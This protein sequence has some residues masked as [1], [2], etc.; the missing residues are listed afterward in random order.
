MAQKHSVNWI[1]VV[2]IPVK[3]KR[4]PFALLDAAAR[5]ADLFLKENCV[6]RVL[7]CVI[8]LSIATGHPSTAQQMWPSKM[9]LCALRMGTVIQANANLAHYSV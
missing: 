5:I 3:K 4:E 9:G 8:C 2:T 1:V 6:G 7:I